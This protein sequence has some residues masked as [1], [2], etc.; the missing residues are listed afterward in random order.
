MAEAGISERSRWDKKKKR[1]S[2]LKKANASSVPLKSMSE[3][4]NIS[5]LHDGAG[6]AQ[7]GC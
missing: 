2:P 5:R 1:N 3:Q 7:P 4:S 6:V